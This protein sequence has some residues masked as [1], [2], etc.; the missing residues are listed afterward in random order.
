MIRR[1]SVLLLTVS[2]LALVSACGSSDDTS[3]PTDA[4]GA[5][6]S[7]IADAAPTTA[8]SAAPA[9]DRTEQIDEQLARA[10]EVALALTPIDADGATRTVMSSGEE[11][12][13]PADPQ[14]IV[15]MEPSLTD[16][17][18]ALGF[19]DR[20]VGTVQ[21]PSTGGFHEHVADQL[22][23]D[24]VNVGA[25]GDSNLEQVAVAD[26]DLIITWDW[27]A[28]QVPEL[29]QIAP[30]VVV[31]YDHYDAEVGETLS[32]EQYN[33]WLVREVAALLGVDDRVEGVMA[34]FRQAVDDGRA[35]L[36]AAVGDEPVA[37]LD[38]RVDQVLL[39]G[40]GF[41]GIS[42]LFYGD[43]GL[44]PDPLSETLPVWEEFSLERVPELTAEHIVTFADGDDAQAR[45][46]ELT[47]SAIWQR[48][49][50]VANGR[51]IVV[52]PGLYYR[53][54]DGP[55]GTAQ[56]IDDLV[57]RLSS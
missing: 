17:V 38:V 44:T 9:S 4:T 50:A 57:D 22:G 8:G 7:T 49:P 10:Q 51:V 23:P 12:T 19:A 54:D 30:T 32:N 14:R 27:Y 13:V 41:D 1:P 6:D 28:D 48:V 3:S 55:L 42:A 20:I 37:L 35:A 24:V 2:A 5:V 31:P 33:T 39:S 47:A 36:D 45:L 43:L 52:P 18:A 21:D 11:L 56:V 15:T 26:P 46:D 29:A 40:Y 16:A 34:D 25:E 53:G